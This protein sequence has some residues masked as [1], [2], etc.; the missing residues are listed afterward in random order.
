MPTF[1][2]LDPYSLDRGGT[3]TMEWAPHRDEPLR[4]AASLDEAAASLENMQAVMRAARQAVV[5]DIRMHFDQEMGSD[6]SWPARSTD[7]VTVLPGEFTPGQG[8]SAG[9]AIRDESSGPLLV[10]S[11]AGRAAVTALS[12]YTIQTDVEGGSITF[13]AKPPHYMME[14]NVGSP[15]R[16]TTGG[17]YDGPNPLPQREWLWL[18]EQAGE[19]IYEL[20][21]AFVDN[22]AAIVTSPSGGTVLRGP[23]G[24]F[25]PV[26][27]QGTY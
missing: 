19:V 24:M 20:F 9:T 8:F 27:I 3:I 23:G 22:A 7:T 1:T 25:V 14:H 10:D 12:A 17:F 21:S 4:V 15:G 13:T 5:A 26:G 11:G 18:S 2:G 6:G 16:Y